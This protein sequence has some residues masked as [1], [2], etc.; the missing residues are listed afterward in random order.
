MTLEVQE[1][2]P[3]SGE[4]L[5]VLVAN[6][7]DGDSDGDTITY[8]LSASDNSLVSHSP[9]LPLSLSLSL[10]HMCTLSLSLTHTHTVSHT[11]LQM[12]FTID[13]VTGVFQQ[14]AVLDREACTPSPCH[15]EMSAMACD[16]A[17]SPM[18]S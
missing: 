11:W 18:C 7:I 14:S 12:F 10:T 15:Y 1:E 13:S 8:K 6:D 17:P 3:I 5:F 16:G 4:E 9:T 2:V